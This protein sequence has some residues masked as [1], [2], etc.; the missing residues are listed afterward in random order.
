MW[1]KQHSPLGRDRLSAATR[2]PETESN[3]FKDLVRSMHFFT[4]IELHTLSR[5][6]FAL[7]CSSVFSVVAV[8][9][10]MLPREA[11]TPSVTTYLWYRLLFRAHYHHQ[12]LRQ[13]QQLKQIPCV[14]QDDSSAA[15]TPLGSEASSSNRLSS[16]GEGFDSGGAINLCIDRPN[17]AAAQEQQ[18]QR[19]VTD[20]SK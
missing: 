2:P 18:Q 14:S 16:S 1:I 3:F 20:S 11:A 5:Q 19:L 9:F 10:E 17:S 6:I 12:L 8:Y 13:Q 7:M 15:L 4:L